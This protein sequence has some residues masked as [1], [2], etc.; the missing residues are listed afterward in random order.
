LETN[1]RECSP[2]SLHRA[3][4]CVDVAGFGDSHRTDADRMAIRQALYRILPE[5]FGQAGV[6]WEDVYFE[7][8]GDGALM[9][10][11]PD[12]PERLMVAV[13]PMDLAALLR[14]HNQTHEPQARIQLRLAIHAGYIRPDE[15]GVVG[16]PL[17]LA[18][19]LLDSAAAKASLTGSSAELVLIVPDSF[20]GEVVMTDRTVPP[21]AYRPA[22]VRVRETEESAW[23]RLFPDPQPSAQ[24]TVDHDSRQVP[25]HGD[26]SH[27]QPDAYDFDTF[28][29]ANFRF[30][31]NIVNTRA[32]D[33]TLAED[34]TDEAMTIAYRKWDELRGHPNPTGFVVVTARRI[35]SRIQRQRVKT[36]PP[37]HPL[38]LEAGL[39]VKSDA[40]DPA[41][42]AVNRIALQQALRIL[43]SD[44]RECF[45]LHHILDQ[46]VQKIVEAL[47]LPEGTVKTRLRTAR[48]ALRDLLNDD[49]G[50]EGLQ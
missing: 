38:P 18:F 43:P 9:V 33:W 26:T 27:S 29:R 4:A 48:Q 16:V 50:E 47:N 36:S 22:T 17:N 11:P 10:V 15:H 35:L 32:Q 39:E 12:V 14:E 37:A 19:R 20:Y 5:A 34:V 13:F 8:R 46:S 23:I 24:P 42:T 21:A 6:R 49:P 3:I 44:Q 1:T 30:I 41:D 40:A 28:Y 45:V 7:D 2:P 31:R 25:G